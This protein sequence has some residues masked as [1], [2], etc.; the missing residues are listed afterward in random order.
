MRR[1]LSA[2]AAIGLVFAAAV[3]LRAG[4]EAQAII[5]KAIKAHGAKDGK[6]KAKGYQG[7]NK[8][9]LHVAGL[10]LEFTQEIWAQGGKF[11]EVMDMTV[12]NQAVKVV[13]VFNGKEGWIKANDK[14]IKV[15]KDILAE[16]KEAAYTMGL[17]NLSGLKDKGVK[18]SL[19]GEAQVNGKAALGVKIS[20]EGKKDIDMYFDKKT[21]L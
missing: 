13:T 10:D 5:D 3:E 16:F 18:L 8:G 12:M 7:K 4:D 17:G 15:D 11:K 9:T 14:E 19:I 6:D 21:G 1:I 2:A 20:K